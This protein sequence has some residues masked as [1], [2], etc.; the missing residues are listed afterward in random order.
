MWTENGSL[1]YCASVQPHDASPSPTSSEGI[2]SI[3]WWLNSAIW[4]HLN[5]NTSAAGASIAA[6]RSVIREVHHVGV[7]FNLRQQWQ[8]FS[9]DA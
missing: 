4:P 6:K 3:L 1:E 9:H 7:A 8:P 5:E 2:I